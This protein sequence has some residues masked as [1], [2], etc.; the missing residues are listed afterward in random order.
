VDSLSLSFDLCAWWQPLRKLKGELILS[1]VW[2]QAI[3]KLAKFVSSQNNWKSIFIF[4]PVA[5]TL[6]LMSFNEFNLLFAHQAD[7][8]V[9][10]LNGTPVFD[11]INS[12][13]A[14]D[15]YRKFAQ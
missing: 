3:R 4:P 11:L 7:S 10:A 5:A 8:N 2:D 14:A 13:R 12:Y 9:S 6:M 1:V 15:I